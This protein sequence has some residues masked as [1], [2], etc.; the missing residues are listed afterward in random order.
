ME[1]ILVIGATGMIG[2]PVARKLQQD[3]YQVRI[4]ARDIHKA[5]SILGTNFEFMEGDVQQPETVSR[6]LE[7]CYGVHVSLKAGPTPESYDKIEHRGTATVARLAREAGVE[8]LTFLSGASVAK[9]NTWF[10]VT[11]AKY[12]AENTIRDSGVGY[13]IF[14]ASWFMES[15]NLFVRGKRILKFGKQKSPVHWIAAADFADMVSKS[16]RTSAAENKT[17]YIYG[18]EKMTL[19]EGFQ[20]YCRIVNPDLQISTMP[21]W[22]AKMIATVS[23]KAEM[24]DAANL[25]AYYETITENADPSETYQLFRKPPTTLI[26]W[27]M[28][29]KK[30]H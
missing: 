25:M 12:D 29:Q 10:Y 17:L 4:L 3:G 22:F 5:Q 26:D 7:S 8:R 11:K 16:Y 14:R 13:T 18:T 6:A 1:R 15:L 19:Q 21:I 20:T 23:R 28:L 27:C 30:K 24:K 2:L 9:E